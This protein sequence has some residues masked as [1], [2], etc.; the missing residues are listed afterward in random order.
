VTA[1]I[2]LDAGPLGLV[3]N[4]NPKNPEAVE[5]VRWLQSLLSNGVRVC[6]PEVS[7]YEVRRSLMKINSRKSIAKLDQLNTV[8]DY[9]PITTPA[10]RQAATFWAQARNQGTPTADD[11]ALDGDMVLVGQTFEVEQ[12]SEKVIVATTNVRHIELF[13]DARRWNEIAMS[14]LD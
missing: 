11:K 10:M 5:C 1:T 14:D 13:M 6:I 3:T 7:D 12:D 4:T 9:L 2:V 8:L